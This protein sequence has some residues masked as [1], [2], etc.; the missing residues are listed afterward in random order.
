MDT[1]WS[2]CTKGNKFKGFL[3]MEIF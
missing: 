2:P 3:S 1:A